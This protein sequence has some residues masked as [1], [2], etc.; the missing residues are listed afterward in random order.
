MTGKW[1]T[2]PEYKQHSPQKQEAK[3]PLPRAGMNPIKT[4]ISISIDITS[5]HSTSRLE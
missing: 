5:H 4:N 1:R 2:A 3:L